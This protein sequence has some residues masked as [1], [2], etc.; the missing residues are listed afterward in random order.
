MQSG[1]ENLWNTPNRAKEE[2]NK[3]I[4]QT[5]STTETQELK[6]TIIASSSTDTK[7]TLNIYSLSAPSSMASPKKSTEYKS[8]LPTPTLDGAQ[9]S[10][11]PHEQTEGSDNSY[12]NERRPILVTGLPGGSI[13][14]RG[15]P[16]QT[17]SDIDE[18]TMSRIPITTPHSTTT[19]SNKSVRAKSS[20]GRIV[21]KS[22][23]AAAG[24]KE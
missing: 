9:S 14:Q 11:F 10:S 4:A 24:G 12:K 17:F 3:V 18:D 6:T 2:N 21:S 5:D 13:R 16:S 19:R 22:K 20:S 23:H 1:A 15:I 8:I 7:S